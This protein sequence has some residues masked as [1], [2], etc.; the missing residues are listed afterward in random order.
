MNEAAT[1]SPAQKNGTIKDLRQLKDVKFDF[2]EYGKLPLREHVLLFDNAM[3]QKQWDKLRYIRKNLYISNK[4]L[5][6][7]S[8]AKLADWLTEN[9]QRLSDN[10]I[11]EMGDHN[12]ETGGITAYF[13]NLQEFYDKEEIAYDDME[14]EIFAPEDISPEIEELRK[15][16][17]EK[18]QNRYKARKLMTKDLKKDGKGYLMVDI[19]EPETP[20]E[21][22][23]KNVDGEG[24]QEPKEKVKPKEESIAPEQTIA[25]TPEQAIAKKQRV[26]SICIAGTIILVSGIAVIAALRK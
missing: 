14:K 18:R 22:E 24:K 25:I 15:T 10:V 3:L 26:I 12:N 11:K 6:S 13:L 8:D 19:E 9:N 7:K 23:P 21:N 16:R 17:K 4:Y 5:E 2:E 20:N 1:I